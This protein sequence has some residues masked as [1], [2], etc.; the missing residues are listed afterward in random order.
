MDSNLR[1]V[2]EFIKVIELVDDSNKESEII[3]SIEDL[4]I[5]L[6]FKVGNRASREK[7]D[8][9]IKRMAPIDIYL[10]NIKNKISPKGSG[11]TLPKISISSLNPFKKETPFEYRFLNQLSLIKPI[12]FQDYGVGF[13]FSNL[14][15]NNLDYPKLDTPMMIAVCGQPVN[16][17]EYQFNNELKQDYEEVE[18]YLKEEAETGQTE[19]HSS[20]TSYFFEKNLED[21]LIDSFQNK[22][23]E[24]D[25]KDFIKR[26][27][28]SPKIIIKFLNSKEEQ[29][30]SLPMILDKIKV[31]TKIENFYTN[32]YYIFNNYNNK[33]EHA[34]HFWKRGPQRDIFNFF[35]SNILQV[36]INKSFCL[37]FQDLYILKSDIDLVREEVY[38]RRLIFNLGYSQSQI[39]VLPE[40]LRAILDI[41]KILEKKPIVDKKDVDNH[42]QSKFPSLLSDNH[43]KRLAFLTSLVKKKRN[44]HFNKKSNNVG[45]SKFLKLLCDTFIWANQQNP[46]VIIRSHADLIEAMEEYNFKAYKDESYMIEKLESHPWFLFRRNFNRA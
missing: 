8:I 17:H 29:P 25:T 3:Q 21:T 2:S 35:K 9:Y 41:I 23:S 33:F 7:M 11:Y 45:M 27:G 43:D 32:N 20:V 39:E 26:T 4:N 37:K 14:N 44:L 30:N 24:A 40:N 42:M 6:Y 46:I 31:E 36:N 15:L 19:F 12:L 1:Q 13:T 28:L 22:V 16:I 38:K 34:N 5:P 10:R 18:K